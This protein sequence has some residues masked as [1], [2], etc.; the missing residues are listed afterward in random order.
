MLNREIVPLN[1]LRAFE[2]AG[3]HLSFVA[4]AKELHV[5]PA[6]ISHHIKLLEDFIGTPLFVRRH[7][8]IEITEAGQSCLEPLSESFQTIENV[9]MRLR[10][11]HRCGPLRVRVA[12][13]LAPKWLLPR[14]NSFYRQYPN[15][16]LE[17]S[18]SSQIYEF[19]YNEMD[20]MMRLRSGDFSGMTVKPFMTEAV[21][22]V[23]TPE[24][25]A[26][27]GPVN[28]P[29]DLLRLPLLHDDNLSV[30]P[31]FPDWMKWL[32]AAGEPTPV[33]PAGHRFDSSSMVLDATLEGRGV[34]LGRS[35][36]VSHELEAGRL[37]RLFDFDYPVTHDYY[38]V[39]PHTTPRVREIECL[40]KWL[41]AEAASTAH[42]WDQGSTK[43]RSKSVA[44]EPTF[45]PA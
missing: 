36:L 31:T 24:F 28:S 35:A 3:R 37:V 45:E 4:A 8:S 44:G 30:V 12:A 33:D 25:L 26:R 13:C 7:R 17:I 34:S 9:T 41:M 6:A 10:A 1:A 38:L 15:I 18:V 22:P 16:D 19:R 29:A 27:Y 39:Y 5:T 32:N 2:A 11:A 21:A 40:H 23:C 20:V 43:H 42:Q 14:L